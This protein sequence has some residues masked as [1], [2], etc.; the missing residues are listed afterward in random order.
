MLWVYYYIMIYVRECDYELWY[1]FVCCAIVRNVNRFFILQQK[2]PT[3][4]H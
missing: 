2:N 1:Y 3:F 4:K